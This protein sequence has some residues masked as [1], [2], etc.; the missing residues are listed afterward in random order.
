MKILMVC[1]GNICRSPLAHGVLQHLA[2]REG[3]DW[4]IDSAG[5]GGWHVGDTP[6]HRAITVAKRYGVDISRQ[7]AQ[8]LRHNHL[9]AFDLI[10]VMD[11]ENLRSVLELAQTAEQRARVRLFLGDDEVPDPYHDNRMFE[12]VYQL[13]EKRCKMLIQELKGDDSYEI[14]KT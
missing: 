14:E 6:D 4:T 3:L 5:V 7:Q 13:V 2:D 1:L 12:P 10:F 9:D 8:Q 11:R